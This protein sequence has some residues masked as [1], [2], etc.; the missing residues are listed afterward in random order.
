MKMMLQTPWTRLIDVSTDAGRHIV[1][2]MYSSRQDNSVSI[3]NDI[4]AV[5][6]KER[7]KWLHTSLSLIGHKLGLAI[8][9]LREVWLLDGLSRIKLSNVYL[10]HNAFLRSV[11]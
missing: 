2:Q 10:L 11:R 9:S 1:F 4:K 8:I 5:D 3:E 6:K 7:I